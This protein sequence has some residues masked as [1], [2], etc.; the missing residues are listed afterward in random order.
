MDYITVKMQVTNDKEFIYW[1]DL[2]QYIKDVLIL[3]GLHDAIYQLTMVDLPFLEKQIFN[4]VI[5]S[6]Y[7][8]K[9]KTIIK[10]FRVEDSTVAQEIYNRF[11]D[12]Y[13]VLILESSKMGVSFPPLEVEKNI[14][15]DLEIISQTLSVVSSTV[16][17]SSEFFLLQNLEPAETINTDYGILYVKKDYIEVWF[18]KGHTD[19][20]CNF[21]TDLYKFYYNM[22][23]QNIVDTSIIRF[24]FFRK[25]DYDQKQ[26]LHISFAWPS[27]IRG[28][29]FV[30]DVVDG[31]YIM[32][33]INQVTE[34]VSKWKT[35]TTVFPNDPIRIEN[36]MKDEVGYYF[37]LLGS[38]LDHTLS[39]FINL[40]LSYLA[41]ITEYLC[42]P[43][44]LDYAE[45]KWVNLGDTN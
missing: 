23:K 41:Q 30:D 6:I 17:K 9:N 19:Y 16:P 33:Y 3:V 45:S 1:N 4:N 42:L 35:V 31:D 20:I 26:P 18:N 39:E 13:A 28:I 32:L 36:R 37:I 5:S 21:D 14:T 22:Y 10:K 40:Q 11:L 29:P 8:L 38:K 7:N 12:N 44:K 24:A 2:Q 43:N 27:E 15:T 25:Y 34:L